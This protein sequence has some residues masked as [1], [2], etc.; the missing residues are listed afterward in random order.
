MYSWLW[1]IQVFPVFIMCVLLNA[2][3]SVSPSYN[4]FYTG[5]G[6]FRCYQVGTQEACISYQHVFSSLVI[7]F[8]MESGYL[9]KHSSILIELGI[10]GHSGSFIFSCEILFLYSLWPIQQYIGTMPI[11]TSWQSEDVFRWNR[12][13]IIIVKFNPFI[14]TR[15]K[16]KQMKK[17]SEVQKPLSTFLDNKLL[18]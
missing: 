2:C 3:Q 14:C 9:N 11:T 7:P 5:E 12:W 16:K 13:H 10:R 17:Y 4:P 1:L 18:M 8:L 15:M 6:P